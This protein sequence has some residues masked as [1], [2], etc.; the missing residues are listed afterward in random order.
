METIRM[1]EA[2]AR[3]SD[4]VSQA[5]AGK[6]IVIR[7]RERDVAVLISP[8]ELEKIERA[9]LSA[10]RLALAL[11][12]DENILKR[13]ERGELHPIMAAFGLWRDDPD[14]AHLAEE[15]DTARHQAAPRSEVDL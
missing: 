4:L 15:I 11:G 9:A 2:K 5:A 1:A 14:L 7:R 3:F 10:Q 13:I 12:Q 6:R 8:A